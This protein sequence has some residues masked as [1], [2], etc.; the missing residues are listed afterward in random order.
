[1][2]PHLLPLS[3]DQTSCKQLVTVRLMLA[4]DACPAAHGVTRLAVE[5]ERLVHVHRAERGP[6]HGIFL[7]LADRD[8]PMRQRRLGTPVVAAALRAQVAHALLA[9]LHCRACVH[10]LIARDSLLLVEHAPVDALVH[11]EVA[12]VLVVALLLGC[13]IAN[14]ALHD[15]VVSQRILQAMPAS[16][17]QAWQDLDL[18]P[19]APCELRSFE[20]GLAKDANLGLLDIHAQLLPH[21]QPQFRCGVGRARLVGRG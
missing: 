11:D 3:L 21:I 1:M 5:L 12:H 18:V 19:P 8:E 7:L 16:G 14:R 17:V 2:V 15:V 13:R 6:M 10:A 9:V 4:Q 20:G